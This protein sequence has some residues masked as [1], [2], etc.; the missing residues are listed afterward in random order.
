MSKLAN[1]KI[2]IVGMRGLGAEVAKNLILAGPKRVDI[3]DPHKAH[4]RDL[5]A[6]FYISEASARRRRRDFA[7]IKKLSELNP[8]T[9][10]KILGDPEDSD[11]DEG[12]SEDESES[13]EDSEEASEASDA[14][15]P[16]EESEEITESK[17]EDEESA[18]EDS[19]EN[20]GGEEESKE[21]DS[22]EEDE[23]EEN[24]DQESAFP[25]D[26]KFTE[27]VLRKYDVVVLTE[28]YFTLPEINSI[29]EICRKKNKGFILAQ[30]LG[31]YGYT[32]VDFGEEF[33]VRD[34]TGEE[35][36]SFNVVGITRDSK[37]EVT[38]HKS[39][40]HN[41]GDGDYVTFREVEGMTELNEL[42]Y[43]VKIKVKDLYTFELDIDVKKFGKYKGNGIVTSTNV[44][45]KVKFEPL[46]DSIQN[47]NL[48]GPGMLN[49]IDLAN[50][51]R[52]GQ[53]HIGLQGILKFLNDH[54]RLPKNKRKE[55][56]EVVKNANEINEI[57]KKTKN[58]SFSV[59]KLDEGVVKLM[60][61]FSRNQIAPMTSFFGGII[62]QE[63]VKFTGKFT[64]MSGQW[65][66]F[67]MFIAL[68][69]EHGLNRKRLNSRYDDQIA[70]FGREFQKK[71]EEQKTFLVGA[72]ALGCEL[73]KAFA[74]MG[75]GCSE[76]GL[77]SVTD[78]DHIELS[79]LNRQFLFRNNHIGKAKSGVACRQATKINKDF[80]S[81]PYESLVSPDTED[82]FDDKFWSKQDYIVNAVDN[83]KARLY[84]DSQC[85]WYKK[86]LFDSGTLGTK[87]NTHLVLP[88][89]TE[90][91]GDTK[92]PEEESIPMCTLRNFPN[93]IEHCIEWGRNRFGELF[94]EHISNLRT[95]LQDRDAYIEKV[96]KENT[97]PATLKH[98]KSLKQ[99]LDLE[100]FEDCVGYAKQRLYEDYDLQISNLITLFPEKHKDSDGNPFW[101]GPKRFPKPL[102]FD[103]EDELQIDYIVACAN[104]IAHCLDIEQN[105][106][107][108]EIL[109]LANDADID[110]EVQAEEVELDDDEEAKKA[111]GGKTKSK[112]D[113]DQVNEEIEEIIDELQEKDDKDEDDVSPEEFE[114][115]DDTN[116]HIDFIHAAANLRARNYK[117][118]ECDKFRSKMIAGKIV[119]AIAT[120][121]AT[122]VGAVLIEL[123]KYIQGFKKLSDY[124]NTY[125]NLAVNVYVQNEPG[126]PKKNK[127]CEEDPVMLIPVK[128]IPKDWT[129]WDTI[130]MKGPKTVK[131]FIEQIKKKHKVTLNLITHESKQIYSEYGDKEK[132]KTRLGQTIEEVFSDL[133][134][135]KVT[136]KYLKIGISGSTKDGDEAL[137]PMVK[138]QVGKDK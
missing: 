45:E 128:A 129:I 71:L 63:I 119:P 20:S 88:N 14:S 81:Q 92:D 32:F 106:D 107:R 108:E 96:K 38:V 16:S 105:D 134:G 53:L 66:H 4:I 5:S 51:E 84:I 69:R 132:A 130:E 85:V 76:K 115:D 9:K 6:N 72:G 131:E 65:L 103:E 37:A 61:K 77:V 55:V 67:D 98:L 48:T 127:D 10:V 34:K 62:C 60:A 2:L 126:E 93:Q 43:P 137:M 97:E 73:L 70:I 12:E 29:N 13:E 40:P 101:T 47:P 79:N 95:F 27:K 31:A 123:V 19:E 121:T 3:Y 58:N 57:Y 50:F 35:H 26:I 110:E 41:F 56:Q 86:A 52:P 75:L 23:S 64:P 36:K 8:Y 117:L 44:P 39:K 78:N 80:N 46:E 74:L 91:Y 100:D 109:Q 138:Y 21:K 25:K 136:S 89:L 30:N 83:R 125:M 54:K 94:T 17:V 124:R 1:M 49:V 104:L 33:T 111:S 59:D 42:K 15:A 122:I 114:K 102:E 28:I 133:Y 68:P 18:S 113:M 116:F 99:L 22:K 82:T 118:E 11:S 135:K 7:C 90:C 24:S 87:A 112:V 120:T